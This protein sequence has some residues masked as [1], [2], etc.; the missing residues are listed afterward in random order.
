MGRG[1]T[2]EDID[3]LADAVAE[4]VARLRKLSPVYAGAI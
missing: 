1:N 4:S 3:A 2:I